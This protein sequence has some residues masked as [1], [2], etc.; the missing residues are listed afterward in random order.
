M[1]KAPEMMPTNRIQAFLS[2]RLVETCLY[3]R[4]LMMPPRGLVRVR[5]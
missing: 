5:C 3:R 1:R 2:Q 4:S